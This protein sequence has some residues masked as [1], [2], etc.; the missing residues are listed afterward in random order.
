M[1]DGDTHVGDSRLAYVVGGLLVLAMV[2]GAFVTFTGGLTRQ[3]PVDP[4]TRIAQF[5]A[6]KLSNSR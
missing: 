2:I 5:H 1:T 6:S 4:N 3:G